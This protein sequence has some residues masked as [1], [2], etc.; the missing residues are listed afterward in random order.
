MRTL[1]SASGGFLLLAPTV[2]SASDFSGFLSG[3]IIITAGSFSALVSLVCFV[4]LAFNR[5]YRDF[6]VA[7]RHTLLA[8]A[9]P[10]LGFVAMMIEGNSVSRDDINDRLFFNG[11][12]L[13]LAML[14][15]VAYGVMDYLNSDV[16]KR[17]REGDPN[18]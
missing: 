4:V 3:I 16:V 18:R 13:G 12:A 6:R 15:L 5:S 9:I 1:S 8:S 7:R 10:M 14:P 17:A 2:A 11:I